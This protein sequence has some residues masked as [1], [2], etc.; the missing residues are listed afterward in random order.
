MKILSVPQLELLGCLLLTKLIDSV[1]N[2]FD[3]VLEIRSTVCWSDSEICILWDKLISNTKFG[4]RNELANAKNE[5]LR[6][7]LGKLNP[8]DISTRI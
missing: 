2:A 7:V 3:D 1:W 6:Y 8:A 5:R 4:L